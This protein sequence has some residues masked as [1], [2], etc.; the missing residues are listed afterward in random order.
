[1][2]E[3][4]SACPEHA[5]ELVNDAG[6]IGGIEKEAEGREKVD[7]GVEP[8]S[9]GWRKGAHVG[10]CVLQ[11]GAGSPLP[12]ERQQ[13]AREVDALDLVSRFREQVGVPTLATGDVENARANRK[14]HDVD[15]PRDFAPILLEREEG[16]VLEEILFVEVRCPPRRRA[17][18]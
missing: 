12:G 2:P 1:V 7:D 17:F 18:V 13:L 10:A 4:H 3:E 14:P 6:V 8:T 5:R 9:P 16:F 15:Q 11:R